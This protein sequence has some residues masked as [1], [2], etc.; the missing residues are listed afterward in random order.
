SRRYLPA[1]DAGAI[2]RSHRFVGEHVVKSIIRFMNTVRRN[3]SLESDFQ[4]LLERFAYVSDLRE[5]EIGDFCE[6]TKSQGHSYLQVVDDWMEQRRIGRG[7]SGARGK[8]KGLVAGVHVIAYIGGSD[9]QL[10][11]NMVGAIPAKGSEGS[12]GVRRG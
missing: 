7:S 11:K 2:T 1:T 12:D 4:P 6:F 10:A 9:E 8:K 5:S 3:T